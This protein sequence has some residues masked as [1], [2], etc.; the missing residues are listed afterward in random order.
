M[1]GQALWYLSRGTGLVCLF[2]LSGS[3]ILGALNSGRFASDAWPRF[4]ISTVHRNLSLLA[5]AFL[6]VHV[7]S[8]VIDPYA[9]I[10]W[11]D[12]IIPFGSVYRP[13]WLGLGA[14]AG[15]LLLALVISSLLRQKINL[16]A[17][18]VLHWAAYAC[19]PVA[20]VHGL[21]TA[22]VDARQTWVLVFYGGCAL[23]VVAAVIWRA[24][25][26]H[27]DT[28]ARARAVGGR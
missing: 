25:T 15:D 26:R 28:E 1:N 20:V 4:V 19:W 6:A 11:L 17:W 27:A 23:P 8:G 24:T 10:G 9:G 22:N 3:M 12:A 18:R 16:R 2:L 5:L 21:G 14:V 7:A 13:M